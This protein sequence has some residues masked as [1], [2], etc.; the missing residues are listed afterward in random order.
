MWLRLGTA[1]EGCWNERIVEK[2]RA[3]LT[4][5]EAVLGKRVKSQDGLWAES[6]PQHRA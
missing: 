5:T 4:H 1:C 2:R 6:I 3:S